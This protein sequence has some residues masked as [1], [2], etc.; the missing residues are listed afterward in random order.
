MKT[1]RGKPTALKAFRFFLKKAPGATYMDCASV[2][3]L[4]GVVNG[5][6]GAY[7]ATL[8]RSPLDTFASTGS[9]GN[10]RQGVED[11]FGPRAAVDQA[12]LQWFGIDRELYPGFD[13][14]VLS[15]SLNHDERCLKL[16]KENGDA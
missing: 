1:I 8:N 12:L 11:M 6:S 16:F 3:E 10:A 7:A 4:I 13:P 15:D 9:F 2:L 14:V 5:I